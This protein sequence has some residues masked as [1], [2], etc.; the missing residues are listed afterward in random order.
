M[1]CPV[2]RNEVESF[3]KRSHVLPDW[4]FKDT[5]SANHKVMALDMI[6]ES[7][8]KKQ[9]ATHDSFWCNSCESQSSAHDR[10][11]S[12]I[13]TDNSPTSPEY[14]RLSRKMLREGDENNPGV[15]LWTGVD[16]KRFQKFVFCCVLRGELFA[17]TESRNIIGEK[18]FNAIKMMYEDPN[19]I[20]DETY[21]ILLSRSPQND[22]YK[23]W[24]F[25]PHRT[26]FFNHNG[27]MFR[28]GGFQFQI[29][30]STHAKPDAVLLGRANK[31]GEIPVV[32][33]HYKNTGSYKASTQRLNNIVK[34]YPPETFVRRSKR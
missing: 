10:Y 13:L 31:H 32:V 20:D 12:L 16:F 27:V 30:A 11:A 33:D 26:R 23:S 19:A 25:L 28:G 3:H 2:C 21:P 34:K 5:Y 8:H 29:Y 14:K 15:E 24:G 1:I 9:S 7:A 6:Q 18:H 4:M 22:Q 17:R